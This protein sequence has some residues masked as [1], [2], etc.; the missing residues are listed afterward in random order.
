MAQEA[1]AGMIHYQHTLSSVAVVRDRA[2]QIPV[3]G[4]AA[5]RMLLVDGDVIEH[6][7]FRLCW[8]DV[9]VFCD[10]RVDSDH[11]STIIADLEGLV[12]SEI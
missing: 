8:Q 7:L 10:A 4:D 2:L 11:G 1:F 3:T 9:V 12:A 5:E 6:C